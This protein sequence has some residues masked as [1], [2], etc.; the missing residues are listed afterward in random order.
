MCKIYQL[1]QIKKVK[2]S[3][4]HVPLKNNYFA[5]IPVKVKYI[6]KNNFKVSLNDEKTWHN[7]FAELGTIN[8]KTILTTII[9]DLRTICTVFHYDNKVAI[10]NEVSIN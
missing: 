5:E 4:F 2:N 3:L 7:V 8:K 6:G 1:C 9:D 10:F